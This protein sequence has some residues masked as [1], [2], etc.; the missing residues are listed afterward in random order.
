MNTW[1]AIVDP[2]VADS[3]VTKSNVE[4]AGR[5]SSLIRYWIWLN[6]KNRLICIKKQCNFSYAVSLGLVDRL[7]FHV[8]GVGGPLLDEQSSS[9]DLLLASLKFLTS[10][11][12]LLHLCKKGQS[13]KG[14]L[15][16]VTTDTTQLVEAFQMTELA[17]VVNALYG[18]LLH[19][20][21]PSSSAGRPAAELADNTIRFTVAALQLIYRLALLDLTTFQV[22]TK[23]FFTFWP[24]LVW[25]RSNLDYLHPK[26]LS[27]ELKEFRSSFG[28]LQVFSFGMALM[29]SRLSATSSTWQSSALVSSLLATTTTK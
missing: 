18:L 15:V 24:T 11:V 14:K 26:R 22:A 27:W 21:A 16:V 6:L 25:R 29:R 17:G 12:D 13:K 3:E 10:L 23:R 2:I 8:G 4:L 9:N 28:T 5:I 19:Q 20:G 7:A 1:V